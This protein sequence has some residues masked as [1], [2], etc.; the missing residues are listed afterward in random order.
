MAQSIVA[1]VEVVLLFGIML[2]RDHKLFDKA[3]FGGLLRILSVTGFSLMTA[4]VMISFFP[5]G[6]NDRGIITLGTKLSSI[7]L[8]TFAAHIAVSW[9]FGLE[10]VRPIIERAKAIL[11]KPVRIQ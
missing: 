3:F 6:I 4:F 9:L 7:G 11:L 5:L 10:E 1:T 2:A 8:V